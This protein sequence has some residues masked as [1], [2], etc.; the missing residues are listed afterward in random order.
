MSQEDEDRK[1]LNLIQQA[2]VPVGHRPEG[3]A[4]ID[5]MLKACA[6]GNPPEDKILRMLRKVKGEQGVGV[7]PEPDF[8]G[9]EQ[10]LSEQ[11]REMLALHKAQGAEMPAEIR[12]LLEKFRQQVRD[13]S[14]RAPKAGDN[15]GGGT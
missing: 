13:R 14:N 11:Q 1:L 10:T 8:A 3:L 4:E 5:A 2:I 9:F 6:G 12:E 15:D 7:R